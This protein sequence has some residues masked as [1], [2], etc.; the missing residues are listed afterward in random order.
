MSQ[1]KSIVFRNI[2]G[3]LRLNLDERK[4][5]KSFEDLQ[6]YL[7]DKYKEKGF[8]L[9]RD[10]IKTEETGIDERETTGW[11]DPFYVYI[12]PYNEIKDKEGYEKVLH[13]SKYNK[14]KKRIIGIATD[15][16]LGYH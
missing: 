10:D 11:I 4:Y 13:T 1:T 5:F 16:I 8:N 6:D 15:K 12:I 9:S 2:A 7:I 3:P 14:D